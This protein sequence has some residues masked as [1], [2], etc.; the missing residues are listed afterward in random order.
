MSKTKLSQRIVNQLS[1]YILICPC[2]TEKIVETLERE[3]EREI[4]KDCKS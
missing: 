3:R 4:V 1:M 2:S